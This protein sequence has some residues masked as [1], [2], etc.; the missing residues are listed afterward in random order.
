MNNPT[1]NLSRVNR[2]LLPMLASTVLLGCNESNTNPD[3]NTQGPVTPQ[4]LVK[5]YYQATTAQR[6]G[7]SSPYSKASLYVWNNEQCAAYAGNNPDANDWAKGL[8]PTGIDD[9]LGAYWEL[10]YHANESTQCINFIPR[11]DGQKPLG[12][13]DAKVDLTQLGAGNAVYTQQGVAA[14]YPELIPVMHCKPIP[15]ACISIR[16]MAMKAS[17]PCMCGMKVNAK[18]MRPAIQLGRA[19]RRADTVKPM[20]LIGIYRLM[21][22]ITASMLSPTIKPTAT[23]KPPI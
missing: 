1:F 12:D 15:R 7:D 16:K 17:S 23:I 3:N 11:I 21:A 20:A 4:Q 13:Y 10:P 18:T 22:A 9:E 19:S 8:L 14:V 5:V 6:S 2:V